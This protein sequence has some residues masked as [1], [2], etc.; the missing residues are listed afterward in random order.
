MLV[1]SAL[2]VFSKLWRNVRDLFAK[3]QLAQIDT[4]VEIR[5]ELFYSCQETFDVKYL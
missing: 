4:G 5:E 3:L 1:L 2:D